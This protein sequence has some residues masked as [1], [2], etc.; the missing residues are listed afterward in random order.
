MDMA[1]AV[2]TGNP[3]LMGGILILAFPGKGFNVF[4][5][6]QH[7]VSRLVIR[8]MTKFRKWY[9]CHFVGTSSET[10]KAISLDS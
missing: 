2:F 6:L 5:S 7:D 9:P 1:E 4:L 8:V 10:P 3:E